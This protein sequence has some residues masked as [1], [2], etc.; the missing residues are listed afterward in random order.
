MVHA[1]DSAPPGRL[2]CGHTVQGRSEG[3]EGG[4]VGVAASHRVS[5]ASCT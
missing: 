5:A 3:A 4:E 2:A 1:A